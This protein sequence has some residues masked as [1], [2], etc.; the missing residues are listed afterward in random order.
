VGDDGDTHFFFGAF[1]F[2][3]SMDVTINMISMFAFIIALGIW[4]TMRLW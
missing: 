4:W 1:L 2:L 3:P